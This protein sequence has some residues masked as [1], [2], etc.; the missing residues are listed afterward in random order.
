MCW[1]TKA[2]FSF[3]ML[4]LLGSIYLLYRNNP[5]DKLRVLF[6]SPILIQEF[7]Q[8][9]VWLFVQPKDTPWTCLIENMRYSMGFLV[10]QTLPMLKAYKDS[11]TYKAKSKSYLRLCIIATSVQIVL[12][13]SNWVMKKMPMC[14]TIGPDGHQIWNNFEFL[15]VVQKCYSYAYLFICFTGGLFLKVDLSF[16]VELVLLS[17][18][19]IYQAIFHYQERL[20]RW[21]WTSSLM[22]VG[23]IIDPIIVKMTKRTQKSE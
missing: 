2:S 20:S 11:V 10:V 12:Y 23:Y 7:L 19:Y 14:T 16:Y 21:C 15:N 18:S 22:M 6:F 17:G 8:G 4:F 13:V 3:A 9:V 1:S 5:R